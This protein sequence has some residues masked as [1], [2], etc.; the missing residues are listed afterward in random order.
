M[1]RQVVEN[2]RVLVGGALPGCGDHPVVFHGLAIIEAK[3]DIAVADIDGEQHCYT[4]FLRSYHIF[5]DVLFQMSGDGKGI[6]ISIVGSYNDLG[7]GA[8]IQEGQCCR[9]THP[10]TALAHTRRHHAA[11]KEKASHN[12]AR[13]RKLQHG[14]FWRALRR[15]RATRRDMPHVHERDMNNFLS[16]LLNEVGWRD[17]NDMVV[18]VAQAVNVSN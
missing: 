16:L 18:R 5:G 12:Y 7:I 6:S 14:I 15:W 11:S 1:A 2:H 3:L 8:R 13:A 17:D 9:S 4:P 10:T